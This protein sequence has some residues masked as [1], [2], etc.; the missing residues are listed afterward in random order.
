MDF[1]AIEK[2]VRQLRGD[3]TGSVLFLSGMMAFLM[4]IMVL[5]TLDTSQVIYNRITAQ[6]AADSAAET[7][8]LW[9]A[10][11]L[12][13]EQQLNDFHYVFDE[14]C[15]VVEFGYLAA[16][17]AADGA[18]ATYVADVACCASVIGSA[19]CCPEVPGDFENAR[20]LCDTC[21]KAIPL[22]DYQRKTEPNIISTQQDIA[23][24][25]PALEM[26][27]ASQAAEQSGADPAL[28]AI[29]QWL[30]GAVA[31]VS[32]ISLPTSLSSIPNLSSIAGG[33]PYAL[34]LNP[35]SL[36]LNLEQK[37]GGYWPWRWSF[38]NSDIDED[39][40]KDVAAPLDWGIA[41]LA[42]VTVFDFLSPR[43][44]I[45]GSL[46][47]PWGWD[48][49]YFIG[50]PGYMTWV[51]GKTNEVELAGLG[52]IAWLNPSSSPP[53]EVNYW[54]G[55]KNVAVFNTS[56]AIAASPTM[57]IPAVVGFASSQTEGIG[58]TA[59]DESLVSELGSMI[60]NLGSSSSA[61][62]LQ[63]VEGV[64][65]PLVGMVPLDSTPHLISVQGVPLPAIY[66]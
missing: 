57:Q 29:P 19:F 11:G 51:A 49:K 58:V 12:N 34:P 2:K 46:G 39:A 60:D 62:A 61:G 22:N 18:V 28:S 43:G 55:Q 37:A 56:G 63:G 23:D 17:V 32:P 66:H 13:V 20:N 8:A 47:G 31:K 14:T 65:G 48:D 59:Q 41:E 1:F 10:R 4:A 3:E 38:F 44:D 35:G 6:N 5:Y 27:F 42:C 52:K 50:H 15:F 53:A 21:K 30:G 25:W 24:F 16:C 64:L 26:I 36:S 9:Q 45:P 40:L 7:A 54:L 33:F